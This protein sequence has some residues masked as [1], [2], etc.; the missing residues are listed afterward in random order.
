[1]WDG[2]TIVPAQIPS[3]Q[4]SAVA[5]CAIEHKQPIFLNQSKSLVYGTGRSEFVWIVMKS[6]LK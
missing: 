3:T 4:M 5:F 6:S 1:M 2:N